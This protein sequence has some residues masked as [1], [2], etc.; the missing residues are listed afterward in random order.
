MSKYLR[1][2]NKEWAL[3]KDNF[4]EMVKNEKLPYNLSFYFVRDSKRKF[5]YINALQLPLDLMVKHN[6]IEDDNCD[7]VLP[8]FKGYEV[9][10]DNPGIYISIIK[11]GVK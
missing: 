11:K 3:N 6:W 1:L 7:I 10:K 9:D 2:H 8:I 5:D 4:K